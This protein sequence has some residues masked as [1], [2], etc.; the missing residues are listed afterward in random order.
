[1]EILIFSYTKV[2]VPDLWIIRLPSRR[3]DCDLQY[4]YTGIAIRKCNHHSTIIYYK[5]VTYGVSRPR[6]HASMYS[7]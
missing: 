3:E 6:A 7:L 2:D 1:M 4:S 5:I